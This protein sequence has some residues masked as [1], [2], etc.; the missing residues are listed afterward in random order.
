MKTAAR[1]RPKKTATLDF[2]IRACGPWGNVETSVQTW[3]GDGLGTFLTSLA[4]DFRG[5]ED[6]L[7]GQPYKAHR[8][9]VLDALPGPLLQ[10][11]V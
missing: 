9:W 8:D 10:S 4:E 2:P 3:D 5:W 11:A 7:I 1:E 6:R